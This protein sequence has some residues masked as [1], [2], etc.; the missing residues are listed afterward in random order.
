MK[1]SLV[2]FEIANPS[3]GVRG[4]VGPPLTRLLQIGGRLTYLFSM[5][6]ITSGSSFEPNDPTEQ[7]LG[8][9]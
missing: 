9:I 5:A 7:K 1:I 2:V 6:E 4:R 8:Y 3:N